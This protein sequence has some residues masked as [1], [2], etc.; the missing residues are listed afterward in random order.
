MV[1]S[2]IRS[3]R[4]IEGNP[5]VVPSGINTKIVGEVAEIV[6]R[7]VSIPTIKK[8]KERRDFHD[9]TKRRMTCKSEDLSAQG[10]MNMGIREVTVM[11][12]CIATIRGM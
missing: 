8:Y 6:G 4:D 12:K 3:Q 7:K 2:G 1:V 9:L 11:G 10:Q 5:S